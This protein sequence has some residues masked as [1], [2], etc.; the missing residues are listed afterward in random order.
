MFSLFM[1]RLLHSL[2]VYQK[3]TYKKTQEGNQNRRMTKKSKKNVVLFS[4]IY[5]IIIHGPCSYSARLILDLMCLQ[6]SQRTNSVAILGS[7]YISIVLLHC[8]RSALL[9]FHSVH[10]EHPKCYLCKNYQAVVECYI[11]HQKSA[12]LQCTSMVHCYCAVVKCKSRVLCYSEVVE[13]WG[14]RP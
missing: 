6:L 13:H 9:A 10:F 11:L 3:R 4:Y 8:Y 1:S 12:A 7:I 14:T 5:V 2:I